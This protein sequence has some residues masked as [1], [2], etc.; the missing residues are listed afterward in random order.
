MFCS[1]GRNSA[2]GQ[3]H[4]P[5]P[6][7]RLRA[8][9]LNSIYG[10]HHMSSRTLYMVYIIR[11]LSSW[12]FNMVYIIRK[13]WA[14]GHTL[15]VLHCST[16]LP[17]IVSF[18]SYCSER[19]FLISLVSD[20]FSLS[21]SLLLGSDPL[22]H[23]CF[24]QGGAVVYGWKIPH[25]RSAAPSLTDAYSVSRRKSA[26]IAHTFY[27]G[28][29]LSLIIASFVSQTNWSCWDFKELILSD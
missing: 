21:L 24:C 23:F 5:F 22:V 25:K 8:E 1:P 28:P 26:S 9:F 4:L 15:D 10:L 14:M 29:H 12:A 16:W 11:N 6:S 13:I 3:V 18:H 2:P 20:F 7:A 19:E 17:P 27:V